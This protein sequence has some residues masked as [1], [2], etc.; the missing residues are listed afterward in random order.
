MGNVFFLEWEVQLMVLLQ[1]FSNNIYTYAATFFAMLGE[2]YLVILVLGIVYWCYDKELG[3]RISLALSGAMISGTLIKGLFLRRR[4]YMDNSEVKCIRA[5]H[6]DDDIMS[7][8]AQ[9]FSMPS[10]HSAMSV[11]V[12][13]TLA[14]EI[15]KP[16]F[17]VIG[18][19]LPLFIGVSRVYL[20]VHYPTDVLFGWFLGLILIVALNVIERKYGYKIGFAAILVVGSL[21]F[22]FC[23]DNEFFSSWGTALGLLLGFIFE[24]KYVKFEKARKWQSYIIRPVL[25]VAIFVVVSVILKIPET[26]ISVEWIAIFLR[27]IRYTVSTFVIIG[28]YPYLFKKIHFL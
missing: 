4:P 1:S 17:I 15:K 18:I 13:G 22:F 20:G 5:P 6:P 26:V 3:R 19:L 8:V 12:Y 25:G 9:G 16:L 11:S 23:H 14:Y 27:L 10:L 28:L 24:E 21:G 2:E 7:P